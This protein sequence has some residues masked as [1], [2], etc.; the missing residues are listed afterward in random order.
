MKHFYIEFNGCITS[1]ITAKTLRQAVK[2]AR[3]DFPKHFSITSSGEL[4]S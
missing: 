3:K 2:T 4:Y 1:Y